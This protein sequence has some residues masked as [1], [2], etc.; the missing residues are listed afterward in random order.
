MR[1]PDPALVE[2]R[3]ER[4]VLYRRGDEVDPFQVG[5]SA[6][7]FDER[8]VEG[9]EAA[10]RAD[11]QGLVV[12]AHSAML[13]L[14]RLGYALATNRQIPSALGRLHPERVSPQLD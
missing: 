11:G 7:R 1:E 3:D 14:S 4:K 6:H 5:C 9:G 8:V 12:A 10:G 2:R 13:G